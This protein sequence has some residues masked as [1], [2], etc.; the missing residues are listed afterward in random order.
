LDERSRLVTSGQGLAPVAA[1]ATGNKHGERSHPPISCLSSFD[2]IAKA[3]PVT[4]EMRN[5]SANGFPNNTSHLENRI[6]L[7]WNVRGQLITDEAAGSIIAGHCTVSSK[8]TQRGILQSL[9][10]QQHAHTLVHRPGIDADIHN[11]AKT[12]GEATSRHPAQHPP[13]LNFLVQLRA[14]PSRPNNIDPAPPRH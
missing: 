10:T 2:D 14:R 8:V 13:E 12:D 7:F 6:R 9:L 3:H 4:Q 1:A 11:T 5:A